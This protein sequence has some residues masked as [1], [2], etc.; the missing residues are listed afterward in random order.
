MRETWRKVW[1]FVTLLMK[2][3][4]RPL[5]RRRAMTSE[6]NAVL[7]EARRLS[8]VPEYADLTDGQLIRLA[9]WGASGAAE[10]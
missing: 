1:Q 8:R 9:Y 10:T 7:R 4:D 3:R 6:G 5:W 2:A